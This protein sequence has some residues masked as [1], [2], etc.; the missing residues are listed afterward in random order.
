M[1][2]VRAPLYALLVLLLLG[3]M[4]VFFGVGD[5]AAVKLGWSL[6]QADV[7][8][9]KKLLH[10][11][12]KIR[13]EEIGTIVLGKE[14]L[15]LVANYLLNRIS[16]SAVKISLKNNQLKFTATA[17]LPRNPFGNYVN[18]TIALGNV[19]GK[20]LPTVTKFKAG[21][22]LL[23]S[24]LAAYV[25]DLFIRHS[26]LNEYFLLATRP[27]KA[28]RIT[29]DNIAISYSSNL[30]TLI[31]ARK[32]LIG[33]ASVDAQVYRQKINDIVS[34]HDPRQRL[35]L[36]DLLRP[37]FEL[38]YQRSTLANAIEENRLAII[39]VNDYA[40]QNAE[41]LLRNLAPVNSAQQP[42]V[43]LYQRED[44][45]LHFIGSA[46]MAASV[47]GRLSSAVG[48]EK[49]LHDAEYGSG[50]SFI[51]LAADQAGIRFGEIATSTPEN[52]RKI[53]AAMAKITSYS[54]FM[55]DPRDLPEH[56][57]QAEFA[58]RYGSVRSAAY[59]QLLQQINERIAAA[60]I[61]RLE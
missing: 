20:Q 9:A 29:P 43:F 11:G 16:K 36:A 7:Q 4:I 34:Q 30:D 61:Y 38:A 17:T 6:N 15:N 47:D 14:D 32:L 54:D 53:Q 60:P 13:P 44:L 55:P 3:A 58:R 37:S 2:L 51:D 35:S 39:A 24:G 56:M 18:V 59:R 10:E 8:R 45:A 27:I 19:E 5:N 33:S 22:L 46:A 42:P 49:E 1:L 23:P 50:F 25:I 40:N 31:R 48:E 41:R 12:S 28:V 52:A 26:P 21:R 57:N